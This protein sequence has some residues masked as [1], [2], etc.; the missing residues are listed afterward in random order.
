MPFSVLTIGRCVGTLDSAPFRRVRCTSE[1]R[2]REYA[3]L[4]DAQLNVPS[5]WGGALRTFRPE[6]LVIYS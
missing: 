3:G 5:P 1:H 6:R 2:E 4:R